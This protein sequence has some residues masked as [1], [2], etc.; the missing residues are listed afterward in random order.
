VL[1]EEA[2]N[3]WLESPVT[4]AVREALALRATVLRQMWAERMWQN[5]YQ[6]PEQQMSSAIGKGEIMAYEELAGLE[7]DDYENFASVKPD[8]DASG[9]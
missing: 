6:T 5:T 3:D 2:F 4:K 1:T 9:W 8:R 7:F